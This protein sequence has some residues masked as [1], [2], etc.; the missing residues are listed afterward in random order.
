MKPQT[1]VFMIALAIS[2]AVA[3][4]LTVAFI[5]FSYVRAE[6]PEA[7]GQRTPA[8]VTD[9]KTPTPAATKAP[10]PT[11]STVATEE[12]KPTATEPPKEKGNGLVFVSYGNGTSRVCGIGT[13]E[14]ACVVIP[15]YDPSG[16]VVTSIAPSA[17]YG[18]TTVSA[19]QIPA[20]VT[21][22]GDA[23]FAACNNLLYISVSAQNASY[24]DVD[25]VL[26]SR[27][28]TVLLQYPALRAGAEASLPV[29]I[30]EI[31]SMA[32]YNCVYLRTVIYEGTP[33][34][35]ETIEI[36]SKNYSL[37]AAAK[38]FGGGK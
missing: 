9:P 27:D 33:E 22:I 10:L 12:K 25:G 13:C 31:R 20:T 30:R 38:R 5:C 29:S 6:A 2:L 34:Q 1:Q 26:Y 14:D 3:L 37:T 16:N 35:W 18:C 19:V 36:G 17:F 21:Y 7:T 8:S 15:E 32:F 24:C 28:R 4:A 23:A 11:A